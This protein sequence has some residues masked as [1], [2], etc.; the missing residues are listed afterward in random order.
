MAPEVVT[1]SPY[2][3][4][5]IVTIEMVEG[6]PP[7]F[8]ETGAMARALIRQNG[9]PRLQEPRRLSALLRDFLECS[10]ELD[11]ERRWS[12]QEL[13]QLALSCRIPSLSYYIT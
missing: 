4:F 8:K 3:S 13:L 9:T 6:E 5:S 1:S 2:S 11:E 7:Y 12:A 10:L